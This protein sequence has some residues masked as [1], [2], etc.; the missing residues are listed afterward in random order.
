MV[1]YLVYT[2]VIFLFFTYIMKEDYSNAL[3]KSIISGV[4]FTVFCAYY[5]GKKEKEKQNNPAKK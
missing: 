2:V 5:L 4:L 3:V 1:I